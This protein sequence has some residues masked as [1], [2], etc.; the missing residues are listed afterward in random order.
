MLIYFLTKDNFSS[1]FLLF[2]FCSLF[3]FFC[4]LHFDFVS[5]NTAFSSVDGYTRNPYLRKT[6]SIPIISRAV[7][8]PQTPGSVGSGND[9][10]SAAPHFPQ[11]VRSPRQR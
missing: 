9:K 4:C 11:K 5:L 2:N 3:L 1:T 8:S 10:Q 7:S 6:T